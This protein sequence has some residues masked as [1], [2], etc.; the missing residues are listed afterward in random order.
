MILL[1]REGGASWAEVA[2]ALQV[3][4][5]EARGSY[6]A[7]I[8]RQERYASDLHDAPRACAVL[9]DGQADGGER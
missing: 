9:A 8:D 5:E 7:A 2:E 4:V 6:A 1:A 3:T